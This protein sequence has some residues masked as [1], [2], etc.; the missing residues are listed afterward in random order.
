M[1][2]LLPQEEEGGTPKDEGHTQGP[3]DAGPLRGALAPAWE[4]E[5]WEEA[6]G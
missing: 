5:G 6:G 3:Q 4:V 1:G 2:L